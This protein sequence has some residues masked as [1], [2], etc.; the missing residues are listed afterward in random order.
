MA[1]VRNFFSAGWFL[2]FFLIPQLGRIASKAASAAELLE[3]HEARC[4]HYSIARGKCLARSSP[5]QD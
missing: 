3:G 5:Q 2:D 1:D 4:G